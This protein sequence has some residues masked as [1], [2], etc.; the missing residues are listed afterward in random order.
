MDQHT[1]WP[2]KSKFFAKKQV[3]LENS[4]KIRSTKTRV[5]AFIFDKDEYE[6]DV[7]GLRLAGRLS[8][9]REEL[10]I[11]IVTNKKVIKRFRSKYEGLWF[12]DVVYSTIVLKR[13]D[14]QY[15][16]FDLINDNKNQ[17]YFHWITK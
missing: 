5:V 14:S 6:D 2:E 15:F 16:K 10:R 11:G 12:P 9:K 17:G 8:A 7:K 3:A 1:E 4:Y 13:Y